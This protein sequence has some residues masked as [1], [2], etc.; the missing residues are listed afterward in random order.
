MIP[1]LINL[2]FADVK[3][4][5]ADMG[6]ALMG[7]AN[8]TGDQRAIDA[9]NKAISSPLLDDISIDGARGVLINIT[10]G[11]DLGLHE[12]SEASSIIQEAAHPDANIIFG[13][14]IDDSL[15]ETEEIRV[16]VIAT[17][18]DTKAKIDKERME[19]Q[20]GTDRKPVYRKLERQPSPQ[21]LHASPFRKKVEPISGDFVIENDLDV[22]TFIR[23]K[24]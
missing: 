14:V 10:G 9:A 22:P 21:K 16:T 2:D 4:I 7:A 13:A 20:L 3:T 5:M 15:T 1:G 23:K 6:V 12:I 24:S 8:A 17:G 18:F 19:R 11:K